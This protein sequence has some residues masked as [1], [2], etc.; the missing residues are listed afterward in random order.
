MDR[1]DC[2]YRGNY[3]RNAQ[4][5]CGGCRGARTTSLFS[6][7]LHKTCAPITK[8]P[9]K[10][11]RAVVC[12]DCPD[13]STELVKVKKQSKAKKPP[14]IKKPTRPKRKV[15]LISFLLEGSKPNYERMAKVLEKS[16]K[17]F[18]PHTP[19]DIQTHTKDLSIQSKTR[20]NK[21]WYENN[22]NKTALQNKVVQKARSGSLIGFLDCDMVVLG[23]LSSIADLDFDLAYTERDKGT[24]WRLNTGTIFVR[25]SPRMKEFYQK[26]YATA[27]DM[28]ARPNF[29]HR[30]STR[31]GGVN[32]SSLAWMIRNAAD[33]VKLLSL[34]CDEWNCR[35]SVWGNKEITKI[36]HLLRFKT[37]LTGKRRSTPQ[38]KYLTDLW[39]ELEQQ[40]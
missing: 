4:V 33:G 31:Y 6:C 21:E 29:L 10:T 1:M 37:V 3:L 13:Y 11:S 17:R 38:M 24:R 25:V 9:L 39:H 14:T 26:W 7:D 5:D 18:S 28:L 8:L 2:M 23:D 30:F 27:M 36:I 32:Q 19:I 12:K 22:G 16:V 34:H 35:D 40:K 15:K 20:S